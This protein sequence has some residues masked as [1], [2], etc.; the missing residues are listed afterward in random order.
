MK[1]VKRISKTILG[2]KIIRLL[3]FLISKF[4]FFSIKWDC[5]DKNTKNLIFN[6][7]K[8]YIFCSWHNRLF[9]GPYFLP[10][11][12]VI[13]VLQSNHS[14]GMIAS[15]ILK[16]LKMN[17][18]YGSSMRGGTSAFIKMIK[19]IQKG[20]SIAIIPD[21][22]KGPKQKVKDGIIKLSQF[23][24]APIVPVVWS[25]NKYKKLLTW[26]NFIIPYPFSKGFYVFGKPIHVKRQLSSVH[27][28]RI[29][30]SV[31]DELNSLTES[32][33]NEISKLN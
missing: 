6:N 15:M 17:I 19:S 7:N 9:L 28:K 31:E 33:E 24:G 18:I 5:V 16:L 1:L 26:D 4:I 23:T 22:P 13:N 10:K 14:D 3:V 32:I 8:A 12:R 20:E 29:K 11:N 21:G 30:V 25:T 27:F 2:Q